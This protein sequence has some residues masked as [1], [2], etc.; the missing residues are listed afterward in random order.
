MLECDTR[1]MILYGGAGSGKS[2]FVA[3]RYILRMMR[4]PCNILVVRATG[5]SNRD[6]TFALFRQIIS[7]W[8]VGSLFSVTETDMRITCASGSSVVFKGLDDTEKLKSI[9]FPSGDLTDVWIE[10]AT[11]T[12]EADFNQLNLRLRGKTGR[13]QI[14]ISFNP[15]DINHWLKKGSLTERTKT[16][17]HCG[18]ITKTTGF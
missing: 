12:L 2:H 9:T 8:G 15:V 3:Q 13:K 14:V 6:S 16:S 10:E 17:P 11:E 4:E 1:Y 18:Q 7:A 5:N